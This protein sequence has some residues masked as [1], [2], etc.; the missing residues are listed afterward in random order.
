MKILVSAIVVLLA[1]VIS[2]AATATA[3]ASATTTVVKTFSILGSIKGLSVISITVIL[4]LAAMIKLLIS[5]MKIKFIAKYFDTPKI[6]AMKPYFAVGLGI[7]CGLAS[8]ILTSRSIIFNVL[9]GAVIGFCATGMHESWSSLLTAVKSFL[10]KL[11]KT[12]TNAK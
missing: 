2:F 3:S 4:V 8:S 6:Q 10:A 9:V 7:I 5:L 12:V 11:N 1:A